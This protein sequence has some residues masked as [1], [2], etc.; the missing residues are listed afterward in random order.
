[1]FHS[2][3]MYVMIYKQIHD[4][5]A[6]I[7]VYWIWIS[8]SKLIHDFHNSFSKISESNWL[9]YISICQVLIMADSQNKLERK[10]GCDPLMNKRVRILFWIFQNLK[11]LYITT[12]KKYLLY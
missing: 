8:L 11:A 7:N 12:H 10:M 2:L 4:H 6:Y 9:L 3:Y 5:D 1:M